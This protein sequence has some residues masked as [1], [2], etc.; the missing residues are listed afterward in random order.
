MKVNAINNSRQ[1]FNAR[2]RMPYPD[3]KTLIILKE[4][5]FK[6]YEKTYNKQIITHQN[7]I[8]LDVFTGKDAKLF[9]ETFP[10]N[11]IE[12]FLYTKTFNDK[13]FKL[14]NNMHEL[15]NNM[16]KETYYE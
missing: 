9:K 15:Q 6:L 14:M 16:L 3:K 4:H 11:Y 12:R 2:Y 8:F 13:S 7:D 1:S 10:R 5:T